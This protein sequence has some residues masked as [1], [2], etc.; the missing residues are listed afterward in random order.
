MLRLLA[1]F[2]LISST[3]LFATNDC[4]DCGNMISGFPT[5]SSVQEASC[6]DCNCYTR[7]H[8][9]ALNELLPE[10]ATLVKSLLKNDFVKFNR[11]A[12][13]SLARLD[14]ILKSQYQI[15]KSQSTG[16]FKSC[17]LLDIKQRVSACPN[18]TPSEKHLTE[19]F[20]VDSIDTYLSSLGQNF[21]ETEGSVS[22][23]SK[24]CLSAK[25]LDQV[26]SNRIKLNIAKPL[27]NRMKDAKTELKAYFDSG[28]KLSDLDI[29]SKDNQVIINF[30][31]DASIDPALSAIFR[32]EA[33]LK[34][35]IDNLETISSSDGSILD[36][37]TSQVYTQFPS[38][39]EHTK[40]EM[41]DLCGSLM[42][43]VVELACAG[44]SLAFQQN[45]E[46]SKYA[47]EYNPSDHASGFDSMFVNDEGRDVLNTNYVNHIYWCAG[48]SCQSDKSPTVCGKVPDTKMLDETLQFITDGAS[49]DS[50]KTR[51][52]PSFDANSLCKLADCSG[53][54]EQMNACYEGVRTELGADADG[55]LL[56]YS[57]VQNQTTASSNSSEPATGFS[58]S[59]FAA[60]FLGSYSPTPIEPA[61]PTPAPSAAQES[62][63]TAANTSSAA[64]TNERPARRVVTADQ[65]FQEFMNSRFDSIA[66]S[67]SNFTP[68]S[69]ARNNTASS[70]T[71][72]SSTSSGQ[73]RREA[74]A[75]RALDQASNT[76][77]ELRE[78]YRQ[79]AFDR[80][81]RLVDQAARNSTVNSSA[82]GFN[83][84]GG[85]SSTTNSTAA[86]RRN[87]NASASVT[88]SSG[89]SDSTAQVNAGNTSSG[90]S[91]AAIGGA[92]AAASAAASS[93]SAARVVTA[94]DGVQTLNVKASELPRI[95]PDS[96][97]NFGVDT[98]KPFNIAVKVEQ[99]TYLVQVRPAM[100]AGTRM[101]EPMLDQL[102]PQ[103]RAQVLKSPLFNQY[104]QYLLEQLVSN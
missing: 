98:N 5:M 89:E 26:N 32:D 14:Q 94:D 92:N 38:V 31:A 69:V 12:T 59:E 103:L 70:S 67:S 73:S 71:S 72:S 7:T 42:N 82:T 97:Q 65:A 33:V 30:I 77:E 47:F 27:L 11:E 80:M 3:S 18:G 35:I 95:T 23:T 1:G 25:E 56:S 9:E 76:I 43:S 48:K 104:R 24:S 60:N 10:R 52:A 8:D 61:S 40:A 2:I 34:H 13:K 102:T 58:R 29:R 100:L 44:D 68:P 21:A 63:S 62:Q 85:S 36:F 41:D 51:I 49:I 57:R 17:S 75:R 83:G 15:L 22:G 66:S 88:P 28:K 16:S 86:T 96:V 93:A 101:L 53:T 87:I 20:G 74:Q 6:N 91:P 84:F 78:G 45:G 79:S 39:I 19:V 54:Q 64:T 55:I 46:V 99:E 81:Q 50:I 37:F 4:V 90:R